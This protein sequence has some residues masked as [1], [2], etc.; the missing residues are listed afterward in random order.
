MSVVPEHQN[1]KAHQDETNYDHNCVAAPVGRRLLHVSP[2]MQS[3]G[4]HRR[5]ESAAC[6]QP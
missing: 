5:D 6:R 1:L 2:S 3:I 4:Y